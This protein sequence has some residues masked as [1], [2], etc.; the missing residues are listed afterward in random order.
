MKNIQKEITKQLIFAASGYARAGLDLMLGESGIG[1][2]AQASIGNLTI[3]TELLIK[4]FISKQNLVLLFNIKDLPSEKLFVLLAH[5][6]LPSSYP[7]ARCRMDLKSSNLEYINFEKSIKVIRDFLPDFKKHHSK[8][9][10]S[11]R[12]HRNNCVHAIHP[13][14]HKYE[15]ERTAYIFLSLL[16]YI[17]KFDLELINSCNWGDIQRNTRHL[18][19]FDE[20][21]VERVEEK[22]EK[23]K[24]IALDVSER[25]TLE[26][27]DW[28]WCPVSC[29][30]CGGDGVLNGEIEPVAEPCGAC[31]DGEYGE[32]DVT[33]NFIA[34]CFQCDICGLELED[35]DEMEI[36][37]VDPSN[38]DRTEE[39]DFGWQEF[40]EYMESQYYY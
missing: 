29:P 31:V 18:E 34:Y 16:Q 2:N 22:I 10:E 12:E 32:F 24:I 28:D 1:K 14:F 7:I 38:R 39:F 9:L 4:A 36:G 13:E 40:E 8:H 27:Y 6:S 30:V 11:L 26:S 23:A 33:L 5:Q 20:A 37:G 17:E 15:V 25:P 19:S 21:R 35:Y 3:A